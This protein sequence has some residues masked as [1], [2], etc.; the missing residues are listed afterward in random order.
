MLYEEL[1]AVER[2]VFGD[3]YYKSL[4]DSHQFVQ[5]NLSKRIELRSYQQEALGRY[6]YYLEQYKNKVKPLHLLF[7]MATGSG[8]TVI[9]AAAILDLYSKGHR[10]FIFFTRLGNIVE[11]TKLNFL[12]SESSKYLFNDPIRFQGSTIRVNQ[13]SSFEGTNPNDINIMFCTT[14]DLHY[15]L[16]N[17]SENSITYEELEAKKLVLIA[18]E[19]HNLSAETSKRLNAE[20]ELNIASWEGTVLRLLRLNQNENVLLEFTATARLDSDNLEILEKYKDKALYRYDLKQYR[21]DGYSKDVNTFEV[22]APLMERVLVSLLVSQYRLKVAEHNRL[23][24]KPVVLFKANRVSIPTEKGK[25]SKPDEAI[26]VSSLFKAEFHEYMKRL[27]VSDIKKISALSNEVLDR[28][29]S[30]FKLQG[31]TH[32]QLVR[33]LQS[34]FS[35]VN[36]LTVDDGSALESKQF[37]LNTLEDP[38][39]HIRAVFATQKLNEGWDVLNLYDIV[40][41]YNSRDADNNKAGKTTVEEAQLIGRGARYYPFDFGVG[42]D[43]MRRKFDSDTQSD[44]R[45][46]EELHYHSKTNPRYIQEL[47]SVL[48]ETGIIAERSVERVISVKDTVRN[49]DF[50]LKGSIYVNSREKNFNQE[51][52]S[53]KDA[54]VSFDESANVNIYSLPTRA[55]RETAI[56]SGVV[57]VRSSQ[58]PE[59]RQIPLKNFGQNLLRMALW[60]VRN[61]SFASLKRLFGGLESAEAFLSSTDFIGGLKVSVS[62]TPTQ[63]DS[64]E[65][66]EKR[67][68]AR[69]VIEKVLADAVKE[70]FEYQGSRTFKPIS[71][72]EV[73]G[74]EK[75]LKLEEGSERTRPVSE[76]ELGLQDWFAQNEIWGTSEEKEFVKFVKNSLHEMETLFTGI[77]LFR[78]EK[79]F[80]LYSFQSGEAFYPDFV[81][82]MK[83][84][85][86]VKQLAYQV[87]IE[88]KGDQ[89]LDDQSTFKRSGEGWKQDFLLDMSPEHKLV[90][91][92]ENFKLVGLPFFNS[93]NTNSEL[94]KQ[95]NDAFKKLFS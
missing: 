72:K 49:S 26:V 81:L 9:M 44:L 48:T 55:V 43:K 67:S 10:N 63:L 56:F 42:N 31:I 75:K 77:V 60:D 73:F 40:R 95:F 24:I 45:I 11:K 16:N 68:I 47:R 66:E 4:L 8:K 18:D 50:W 28:A 53:L 14:A 39:N 54:R 74:Q 91:E 2:G 51:I 30:F 5:E 82:F 93:G 90:I 12:Q 87:F 58:L 34:D 94:R 65:Q 61:G 64:L 38:D 33:E 57:S 69:F 20:E 86:K 36:C 23:R 3:G 62:G 29:F 46:L 41:L 70:E 80:P 21:L 32:D 89:F 88:P 13:V 17:P 71:I 83:T 6:F 35:E 84:R 76:F 59:T 1:T 7:N 22:D 52:L 25:S 78:N 92:D 79:H 19:A 27:K 37:L 15:K 85:V